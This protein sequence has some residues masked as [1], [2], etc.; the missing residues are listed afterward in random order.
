[1][2]TGSYVARTTYIGT[3]RSVAITT[4]RAVVVH[5]ALAIPTTE[6][7]CMYCTAL[8]LSPCL[9]REK[10]SRKVLQYPSHRILRYVHGVL[11]VDENK[12]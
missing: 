10:F 5:A 4:A 1:M 8:R 2:S 11:N 9:V 3:V 7:A 6:P 12:N